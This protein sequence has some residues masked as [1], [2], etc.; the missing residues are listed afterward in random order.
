FTNQLDCSFHPSFASLKGVEVS[1][2]CYI[3]RDC[4]IVQFVSVD[5][6]AWHAGVI[7]FQGRQGCNDI[8]VGNELQG[9]DKK[10]YTEQQYL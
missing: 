1:A 5:D 10:A 2:H 7:E 8:S 3:K 6:R 4:E 9:T